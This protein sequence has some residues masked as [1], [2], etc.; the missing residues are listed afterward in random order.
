[1]GINVQSQKQHVLLS[2]LPS[3][4]ADVSDQALVQ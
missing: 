4:I 3:L 1:M 2:A